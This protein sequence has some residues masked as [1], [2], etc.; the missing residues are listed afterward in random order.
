MIGAVVIFALSLARTAQQISGGKRRLTEV[1]NEADQL[2]Q[3]KN[4]LEKQVNERQS[5]TFLEREARNNLNLVKPGERIVI[6]PKNTNEPSSSM[7][8]GPGDDN[9]DPK[10]SSEPNWVKWKRLFFN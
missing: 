10:I 3:Q 9:S 1:K 4:E 8:K 6:L 5:L 7:D 2:A